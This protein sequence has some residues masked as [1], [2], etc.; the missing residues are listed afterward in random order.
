MLQVGELE[1]GQDLVD[2]GGALLDRY[3]RR[4]AQRGAEGDGVAHGLRTQMHILLLAKAVEARER[5][6]SLRVAAQ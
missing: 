4:Q 5:G 1:I 2:E 3:R 6:E